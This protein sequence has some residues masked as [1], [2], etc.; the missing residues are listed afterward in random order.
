MSIFL[1]SIL[2]D[3]KLLN[4]LNSILIYGFAKNMIRREVWVS[5]VNRKDWQPKNSSVICSKHFSD[6]CFDRTPQCVVRLKPD[7]IPTLYKV[8]EIYI[9][10]VRKYISRTLFSCRKFNQS[11]RSECKLF[12]NVMPD[13]TFLW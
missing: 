11:L 6:D 1:L 9:L 2:F 10:R 5:F 3:L 7:A 4:I 8:K 12:Y 13:K